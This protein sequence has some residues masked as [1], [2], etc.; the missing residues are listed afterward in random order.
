MP[1]RR[2]RRRTSRRTEKLKEYQVV[3]GISATESIRMEKPKSCKHIGNIYSFND[4]V[5]LLE[6]LQGGNI[7]AQ[8]DLDARMKRHLDRLFENYIRERFGAPSEAAASEQGVQTP[9]SEQQVLREY[10]DRKFGEVQNQLQSISRAGQLTAQPQGTP[11]ARVQAP[12]D[13][14]MEGVLSMYA[15]PASYVGGWLTEQDGIGILEV[16]KQLIE[17]VDQGAVNGE[18]LINYARTKNGYPRSYMPILVLKVLHYP[19]IQS[20]EMENYGWREF[21]STMLRSKK[22]SKDVS[23]LISTM[24]IHE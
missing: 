15:S 23:E 13:T 8:N 10:L 24:G 20:T 22:L 12:V 1:G 18:R 21:Y 9:P 2:V 5:L 19:G 7:S 6:T 4:G 3:T 11:E 16:S 14:D 17:S